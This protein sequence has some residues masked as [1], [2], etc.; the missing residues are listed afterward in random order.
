M[1]SFDTLAG[2]APLKK[3]LQGALGDRFPQAVLLSGDDAA[4]LEQWS[5][6]LA[7]GI[8][9]EGAGP[10]PCGACLSCRKAEQGVHPDLT[11]IDEGENE[12]KVD[13]ARRIKAE[14]AVV[15]NDGARRVTVIRHAHNLNPMAQNALLK[16]L[17]E[18]PAYAF[19]VLTAEQPDTL[20][21]TVRSRC[22]RFALAP[23]GQED[24]DPGEAAALLAPYLEALA[25]RREDRM[26]L[27]A[28][29]LEKTPR[30]ALLGVIGV[31]QSAVRDAIFAAKALP[32][33]PLVPALQGQTQALGRTV[34]PE[35]LLAFYE[36]LSVL[37]GRVSRN[38]AAAAVTCALTGDGYRICFLSQ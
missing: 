31:L 1:I 3:A 25:A 4:A 7:A 17:E 8:L 2:N 14:N 18:P 16:E 29:A 6:T 22:T 15:P 36:F 9:C 19:F 26:M 33:P 32:Q 34:P 21:Q 11:V 13:L 38:A 24:A 12:L 28:L 30:R 20:L 5:L 35:R 23:Q 27:A 37:S 10:R